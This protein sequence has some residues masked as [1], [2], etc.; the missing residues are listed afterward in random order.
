MAS[1]SATPT[2]SAVLIVKDEED[3]LDASLAALGWVDEIIV[4]DTGSTD[5]TRELARRYTPD[6]VEGYWDDDFGAA[7]NRALAH[8][9]SEWVL[10][11]DA[12]E[13]FEGS[14]D[15]LLRRLAAGESNLFLVAV[16]TVDGDAPRPE[17]PNVT[18]RIFR[19][20]EYRYAG[21]LHEQVVPVEPTTRPVLEPVLHV[22][23]KH[24]GYTD[25]AIA[26]HD[27]RAR[28]LTIAQRDLDEALARDTAPAMLDLLRT[29]LARA[30]GMAGEHDASLA[31]AAVVRSNGIVPEIALTD[32]AVSAVGSALALELDDVVD[33]WLSVWEHAD[34]SPVWARATRVRILAGRGDVQGALDLLDQLP[35][36]SVDSSGRRFHKHELSEITVSALA[37]T[38]RRRAAAR[39]ALESA[40]AGYTSV[41][42]TALSRLFVQA[43]QLDSYIRELPDQVWREHAVRCVH[44][45]TPG[46]VAFLMAM[47]AARPGDLTVLLCLAKIAPAL[48]LEDL[49]IG[50]AALRKV[51]LAEHCPLVTVSRSEAVEPRVRALAAAMA[52]GIYEDDRAVPGLE[53]ALAAVAPQDEAEVLRQLEIVTPGLVTAS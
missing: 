45:S 25:A 8:A 22:R 27:K 10:V 48:G 18:A 51:G 23:I 41:G 20:S 44:E 11:V 42:P 19:R 31:L 16:E 30:L 12:D 29:N 3:V 52:V 38:G 21:R 36:T 17:G 32:L 46:S 34:R 43:D 14:T 53:A 4:Y 1:T 39:A 50:A 5:S 47:T 24:S 7:R 33:E 6:V 13:I 26:K 2:I 40:R 9:T 28:N 35:T 15:H 49:A 37:A